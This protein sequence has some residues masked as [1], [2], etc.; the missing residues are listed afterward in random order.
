MSVEN[1]CGII[2]DGKLLSFREPRGFK[3]F[4]VIPEE[5]TEICNVAYEMVRFY[6][7][8]PVFRLPLQQ[9]NFYLLI[10]RGVIDGQ[11]TF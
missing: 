10:I 5:V 9:F 3:G 11:K 8:R 2:K 7:R 4:R 1:Y 6:N